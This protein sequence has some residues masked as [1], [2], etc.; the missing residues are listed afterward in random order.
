MLSPITI[1]NQS[2]LYDFVRFRSVSTRKKNCTK[3]NI[4]EGF[5]NNFSLSGFALN[6]TPNN[7][8]KLKNNDKSMNDLKENFQSIGGVEISTICKDLIKIEDLIS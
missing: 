6:K 7:I 1:F 3:N 8:N 5:Q 2:H 4:I